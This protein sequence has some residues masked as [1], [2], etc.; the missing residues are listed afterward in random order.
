[1]KRA[2]IQCNKCEFRTIVD[3]DISNPQSFLSSMLPFFSHL[4]THD[5]INGLTELYGELIPIVLGLFVVDSFTVTDNG[6][7][8]SIITKA[9]KGLYIRAFDTL[10][11]EIDPDDIIDLAN[12]PTTDPINDVIQ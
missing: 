6:E 4:I 2:T 8:E 9:K 1:M 10:G 7:V 11:L 3:F 5:I 12:K